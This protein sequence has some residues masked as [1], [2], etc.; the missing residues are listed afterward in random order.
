MCQHL[1]GS[2]EEFSKYFCNESDENGLTLKSS[3]ELPFNHINDSHKRIHNIL[4]QTD[5]KYDDYKQLLHCFQNMNQLLTQ[6]RQYYNESGICCHFYNSL[7]NTSSKNLSNK[8]DNDR[9]SDD[10][11]DV[12]P[13]L[14]QFD[15]MPSI[16]RRKAVAVSV[17]QTW[18][19]E[20]NSTS[21]NPN[22]II[23]RMIP[24]S[25]NS[26]G[27]YNG[28][29]GSGT[30]V[31][32]F[33]NGNGN[34][35]GMT[36]G[37]NMG[38]NMTMNSLNSNG[39]VKNNESFVNL[40]H[41]SNYLEKG[42]KTILIKQEDHY[43]NDILKQFSENY[44]KPCHLIKSRNL[45]ENAQL[46]NVLFR[47]FSQLRDKH[48]KILDLLKAKFLTYKRKKQKNEFNIT[49]DTVK[50]GKIFRE[51]EGLLLLYKEFRHLYI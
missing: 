5:S 26:N 19:E 25:S 31:T 40:S 34:G 13:Y 22:A 46:S 23:N 45:N 10:D 30:V 12:R 43:L 4:S 1:F 11:D 41:F 36:M 27:L 37:M 15:R 3:L 17:A 2:N 47:N 42:I 39:G 49:P 48:E 33:G 7:P 32:S 8:N 51:F 21:P 14:A 18:S 50:F 38:M 29:V 9:D 44:V 6:S 20:E 28:N 24:T 35:Y 16:E